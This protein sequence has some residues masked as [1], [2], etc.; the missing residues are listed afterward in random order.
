MGAVTPKELERAWPRP[1]LQAYLPEAAN[2]GGT[3]A[4]VRLTLGRVHYAPQLNSIADVQ[5]LLDNKH[6]D[7][8]RNAMSLWS[9]CLAS[10]SLQELK[11][12]TDLVDEA[13]AGL[14]RL[15]DIPA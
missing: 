5:R 13:N 14:Q 2:L 6:I 7:A 12:L 15:K 10:G 8:F 3:Y 9:E 4:A 11:R 1:E